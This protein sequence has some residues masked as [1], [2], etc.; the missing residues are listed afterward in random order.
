MGTG[1]NGPYEKQLKVEM[2]QRKA[3][4]ISNLG[5]E[6]IAVPWTEIQV[7]GPL[8]GSVG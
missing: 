4:E 1:R 3:A 5:K 6:A 8:G 2:Y 7:R